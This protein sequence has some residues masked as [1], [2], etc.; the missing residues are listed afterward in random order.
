M[1]NI[2][3]TSVL[4]LVCLSCQKPG[5]TAVE[6][7]DANG[8]TIPKIMLD[9]IEDEAEVKFT[10]WFENIRMIELETTENSLMRHL[11]RTYVGEEYI[12]VSTADHGILQFSASGK[13]VRVLAAQGGGPGEVMDANRNIFVDEKN[14][15]L[16]T[17]DGQLHRDKALCVGINSGEITYIPFRNTGGESHV[18]DIIVLNDSLMYC[19][20]MQVRGSPS[21]CPVFCQTTS[22]R[23][24]WEMNKTHPKGITNG[25]IRLVDGEIYF[26]YLF[27][28]DTIFR[29]EEDELLPVITS[30]SDHPSAYEKQ[31]I[32]SVYTGLYLMTKNLFKGGISR[33]T[34]VVV[35]ERSG[36]ARP[37]IS[38][39]EEI[40]FNQKTGQV[41]KIGSIK[42]DYLG[43]NDPFYLQIL[44]NRKG[45][46]RYE[47]VDFYEKVDS[48]Y[49]LP[50]IAKNLK[51]RL[52][53]ILETLDENDNHWLLVGEMKKGL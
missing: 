7:V 47:A 31:E 6:Y 44:P 48:M 33:I 50:D 26:R 36:R 46:A 29:L 32:G 35:D 9:L 17:T 18:R 8:E 24:L 2:A 39:S 20:T 30:W 34:D 10:D 4:L 12:I 52:G 5:S 53:T 41:H 1:K 14:D 22:G 37:T 23:L 43:F 11:M 15:K 51:S 45:V 42:N 13:F 49:H 19:T 28:G 40:V 27:G 16:Y 38:D 21:T 25:Q 3:I